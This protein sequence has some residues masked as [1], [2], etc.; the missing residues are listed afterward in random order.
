M[1]E[2]MK[3]LDEAFQLLSAISVSGD[4][5]DVMA[6]ARNKLRQVYAELKQQVPP[7]DT[8]EMTA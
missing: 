8:E 2:T 1:N 6:A 4:A 5:V 7:V 3:K